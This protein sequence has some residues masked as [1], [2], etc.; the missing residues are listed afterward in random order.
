[1]SNIFPKQDDAFTNESIQSLKDDIGKIGSFYKSLPN[2][3]ELPEGRIGFYIEGGTLYC[4]VKINNTLYRT[5]FSP[6]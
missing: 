4:I 2:K 6:I 5:S 3:K 1:M